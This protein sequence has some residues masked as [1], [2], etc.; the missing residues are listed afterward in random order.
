MN[1]DALLDANHKPSLLAE[2]VDTSKTGRLKA[3]SGALLVTVAPLMLRLQKVSCKYP[4]GS[5]FAYLLMSNPNPSNLEGNIELD[6]IEKTGITDTSEALQISEIFIFADLEHY[7]VIPSK[8]GYARAVVQV[9]VARTGSTSGNVY[10]TKVTHDLGYVTSSGDFTS[11]STADASIN[12]YTNETDYQLCSSQVW[13]EYNF[14]IPSGCRLALQVRLYGYIDTTENGKMKLC[15]G[16][17]SCDSYL[18][19]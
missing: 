5:T 19:L 13:L 11:K 12:F 17:G 15:C 14:D 1:E 16:R 10:L 7:D 2:D 9:G 3:R 4:W 6:Y 18:E 8:G